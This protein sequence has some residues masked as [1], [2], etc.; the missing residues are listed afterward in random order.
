MHKNHLL[1][2]PCI[3]KVGPTG[4]ISNP[5][6]SSNPWNFFR[7]LCTFWHEW[8]FF[9]KF[10]YFLLQNQNI[11]IIIPQVLGKTYRSR[12]KYF[13]ESKRKTLI[14]NHGGMKDRGGKCVK[15]NKTSGRRTLS[16]PLWNWLIT[17]PFNV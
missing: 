5:G 8:R 15:F 11:A 7:N 6:K 2:T 9:L 16:L 3:P 12:G 13:L 10:T 4:P 17:I 14:D 1:W